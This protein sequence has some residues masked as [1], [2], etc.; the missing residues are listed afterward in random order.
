MRAGK[1]LAALAVLAVLIAAGWI[2]IPPA[3]TA[4]PSMTFQP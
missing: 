4:G 1:M 3:K 2:I